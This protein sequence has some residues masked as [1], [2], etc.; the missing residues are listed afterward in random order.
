MNAVSYELTRLDAQTFE[1]LVN[2]LALKVLGHGHTGFGPGS[3]GGRDGYFE[4]QAAY[5][6][7]TEN[8]AGV[9]YLQSKFHTPHLSK[10]PQKW[11][12]EQIKAELE[13]FSNDQSGRTW[14]DNWI[15]VTNIEPS[16]RP[17]TGA[18]DR[19]KA[20]VRAK[21]PELS[22]RFDIWGGQKVLDFIALHP[23]VG[24][25]YSQ[26]LSSG[27]VLSKLYESLSDSQANVK[28]IVHYLVATR[29]HD[30]QFT[31]LEQAGSKQ[32]SRPGI[33]NLFKDLPFIHAK[34]RSHE[35]AVRV[36]MKAAAQNH[37][38]IYNTEQ[39]P[40]WE[41]WRQQPS[42]AR[43]WFIKG[44][45][46]QGKSTLTQYICQVQRASLLLTAEAPRVLESVR[47][48]AQQVQD[49]ASTEG[50]WPLAA[51]IPVSIELRH[52]AHWL[53]KQREDQPKSVLN[54]LSELIGK[55]LC[56]PVQVGTLKR[57]FEGSRWLFVFDG[58]D[59]VPS[60]VKDEVADQ[61]RYFLDDVLVSR[62]CDAISIC[63]SRPQGYSGQFDQ[64]ETATIELA[65]LL[66]DEALACAKPVLEIDRSAEESLA[67]FEV[68]SHA[69][70]SASVREIMTTPLQSH[71]MAVVV[72]DGGRPPERRWALF[73]NF[74]QVIKKR[75]GNKNHVD[76][77]INKILQEGDKLIKTLHN[78]LGFDLHA[79]AERSAGA[80]TSLSKKE[81]LKIV[82]E[83][84]KSLQDNDVEDTVSTLMEATTDRLV[85]VS[86]PDSGSAVRFDIRPLQEFFA[87]E[88]IYETAD[89]QNF[90]KRLRAIVSDSHWRE[91]LHFLLSA[92][93]E[94]QRHGEL[95]VAISILIEADEG[96]SDR[97]R[98]LSKRLAVGGILTSRLLKEGVLEADKRVRRQFGN[99]LT[100]LLG[101]VSADRYLVSIESDHSRD[102]LHD[103]CTDAI[104]EQSYQE[105]VGAARVA[106]AI[107]PDSYP[108]LQDVIER[109]NG[110][111]VEYRSAILQDLS[112]VRE[113]QGA[114]WS[115][116]FVLAQLMRD[117]WYL[118]DSD[119]LESA[120]RYLDDDRI[121]S[122]AAPEIGIPKVLYPILKLIFISHYP[123]DHGGVSIRYGFLREHVNEIPEEF[124]PRRLPPEVWDA[125]I[126]SSGL[127]RVAGLVLGWAAGR[128]RERDALL[129][130]VH[131]THSIVGKLPHIIRRIYGEL[132]KYQELKSVGPKGC[133]IYGRSYSVDGDARAT[134]VS[135]AEM[136][137]FCAEMPGLAVALL[138]DGP[139]SLALR[140]LISRDEC[141]V[142]FSKIVTDER[143]A[144]DTLPYWGSDNEAL[145]PLF[146]RLRSLKLNPNVRSGGG[147]RLY[148]FKLRLP[149]EAYLLPTIVDVTYQSAVVRPRFR[150]TDTR[151]LEAL[152]IYSSDVSALRDVLHSST[153]LHIKAA[154]LLLLANASQDIFVEMRSANVCEIF[155]DV[156]T[157]WC[158]HTLLELVSEAVLKGH[159]DASRL[160]D[161]ILEEI[162]E[163]FGLRVIVEPFLTRWR[164]RS[165]SPV[166]D[167][168]EALWKAAE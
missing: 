77:K 120:R 12:L 54:Y 166:S 83:T 110:A 116:G 151:P 59:E 109:L 61:I 19:A 35:T 36:F 103:R 100:A 128:T 113:K 74:Y 49:V 122:T 21:N 149:E 138:M 78:R 108:R 22:R 31:K 56:Q 87:A 40:A 111:S 20:L 125:V 163:D 91:V 150:N 92:L 13:S 67:Y 153:D 167:S 121:L 126:C 33:H 30:Q 157:A 119:G 88:Y 52:L 37:T 18:F 159:V 63:T 53:G 142:L 93:V 140:E 15:I 7:E 137:D 97:S 81:L 106:L 158:I 107:L 112:M 2:T 164:E 25:Y 160:V 144:I 98:N 143:L 135:P 96:N 11:L 66:P 130:E 161:R 24:A 23:D 141:D 89:P 65:P 9:W 10:N 8:W 104:F 6:S 86:T 75:E 32:D 27:Q 62:G 94:N 168:D 69:M 73:S 46:G 70:E 155:R 117:D 118:L 124:D 146:L 3:D 115:G 79:R 85:L 156:K 82:E 42:R 68:L 26:F 102:W 57:A 76:V 64:L 154:A 147:R 39:R 47:V 34:K 99:C 139:D 1:H 131:M 60:D 45:P 16:G 4:G 44:G 51:R 50:H 136:M 114:S 71:I 162:R 43:I 105:N 17:T 134:R 58:L 165:A 5:P 90:G 72:R 48:L 41:R 84:V 95:A 29:F 129:S 123:M 55:S 127:V 148:P 80:Q 133:L 38:I 152:A 145:A 101:S 132:S 28:D 14:P